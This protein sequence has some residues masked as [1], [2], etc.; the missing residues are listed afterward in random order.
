MAKKLLICSTR[1]DA[2]LTWKQVM[3]SFADDV[4]WSHH[5]HSSDQM[6]MDFSSL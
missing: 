4:I 3:Q 1:R 6:L 2:K 5:V